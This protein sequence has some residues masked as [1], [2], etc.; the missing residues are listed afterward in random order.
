MVGASIYIIFVCNSELE[1]HFGNKQYSFNRINIPFEIFICHYVTLR[2][3]RVK[4]AL[5]DRK[6]L[7]RNVQNARSNL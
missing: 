5:F 3:F 2:V 6:I 1:I 7:D 4:F